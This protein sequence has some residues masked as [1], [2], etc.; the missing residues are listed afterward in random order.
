M[1]A[2]G[3]RRHL[4]SLANPGTPESDG[5]GGFTDN[6]DPLNPPVVYAEI[7]PASARDLER[8]M[9]G[10]VVSTATHLVTM[11]YHPGVTT[12]TVITFNGRT[13]SVVGV[14]NPDELDIET[15]AVCVEMVP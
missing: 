14:V 1:I 12:K 6:P 2:S 11:A 3:R 7:K 15:I 8:V 5:D 4:V 9:A 13:F 10:T